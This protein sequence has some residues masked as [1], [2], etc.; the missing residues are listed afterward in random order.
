MMMTMTTTRMWCCPTPWHCA[1]APANTPLQIQFGYGGYQE[2]R[3]S[4]INRGQHFY[5]EGVREELD[6]PGEW[7][8]DAARG[9]LAVF[10][11]GTDLAT[12]EGVVPLADEVVVVNGSQGAPRAYATDIS[13]TGFT[14]THS[15]ATF[16]EAYEVPSGGD[17]AVHRG[18]ALFVQDA[19]RV[20]VANCTF[21]YTGGNGVFFSNHVTD[22]AVTDSEFTHTGDSGVVFAGSTVG[23]DGSAPTY[24][25]HNLVARNH[26]HEWGIYGKQTSC[27][28]QQLSANSTIVDNVCFNGPRAGI[29]FDD[30]MGGGS[31]VVNNVLAN[32][33]RESSDHGPF[34]RFAGR[35]ARARAQGAAGMRGAG[36]GGGRS[37]GRGGRAAGWAAAAAAAKMCGQLRRLGGGT[38]RRRQGKLE[39]AWGGVAGQDGMRGDDEPQAVCGGSGDGGRRDSSSEARAQH[40][41]RMRAQVMRR[42]AAAKM[43]GVTWMHTDG[44]R[45]R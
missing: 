42:R 22:S 18:G 32:F 8:Y 1:A 36:G 45:V 39:Y 2:A 15:R 43:A 19:E 28:A 3:G 5:I 37:G 7:H 11:N 31:A 33:C 6:V 23:V 30:G 44:C 41:L 13:F 16:L 12:A 34:N 25:N 26:M 14:F 38:R 9:V 21:A 29:N 35:T 27:F 40:G 20:L 17:W 4:G 24:P 10:P